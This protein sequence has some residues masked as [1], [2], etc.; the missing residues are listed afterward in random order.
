ML[1]NAVAVCLGE[2]DDWCSAKMAWSSHDPD[3]YRKLLYEKGFRILEAA[4]EGQP[5]DEESQFWVLAH[6][7]CFRSVQRRI[8]LTFG[9][10]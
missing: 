10:S 1:S 5:G 9:A 3:T 4:F 2:E 8:L 7:I 6:K